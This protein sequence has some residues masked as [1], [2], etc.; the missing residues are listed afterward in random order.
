MGLTFQ[1][2]QLEAEEGLEFTEVVMRREQPA[3]IQVTVDVRATHLRLTTVTHHAI[4]FLA[5]R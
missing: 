4:L 2:A 5:A 3:R 1:K